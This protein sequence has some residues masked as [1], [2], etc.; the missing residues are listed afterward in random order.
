[1]S[2]TRRAQLLLG[3][4]IGFVITIGG[5]WVAHAQTTTTP[6]TTATTRASTTT[7]KAATTT[8]KPSSTTPT[9]RRPPN[10]LTFTASPS[11]GSPGTNITVAS[12]NP[13][14]TRGNLYVL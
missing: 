14:T 4:L 10:R 3:A 7:T 8:S 5:G 6:T 11:I 9:T 13:C 12:V 2:V 1:M